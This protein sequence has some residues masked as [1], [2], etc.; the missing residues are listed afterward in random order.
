M[1][2]PQAAEASVS[3]NLNPH[4]NTRYTIKLSDRITN[5]SPSHSHYKTVKFNHKP[6]ATGKVR[7]TTV[8][9]TSTDDNQFNLSIRDKESAKSTKSST[10]EYTGQRRELKKTYVLLFDQASQTATL[11]PLEETYAFNL[12]SAPWE[13]DAAKLAEQYQQVR[14]RREKPDGQ[15]DAANDDADDLFSDGSETPRS[16]NES[17]FGDGPSDEEPEEGNPFDFRNFL[18]DAEQSEGFASPYSQSGTPLR[19]TTTSSNTATATTTTTAPARSTPLQQS[20]RSKAKQTLKPA[21][22]PAVKQQQTSTAAS[23]KRKSPDPEQ[24]AAKPK[25]K[26]TTSTTT[27]SSATATATKPQ[28]TP[29]IRLDRRASAR[30]IDSALSTS[31]PAPAPS[32]Q[33]SSKTSSR[34]SRE[35]TPDDEDDDDDDA[36]GGL[37]IDWGGSDKSAG[38]RGRPRR[39]IALAF[40]QGVTGDGPVSLRSAA[41]SASPNSRLH[42]PSMRATTKHAPDVIEFGAGDEDEEDEDE[43]ERPGHHLAHSHEQEVDDDDDD[44]EQEDDDGYAEDDEDADGDVDPLTLGS[45]AAD[46]L[47]QS[48]QQQQQQQVELGGGEEEEEEDDDDGGDNFEDDFEEQMAQALA[49]AAEEDVVQHEESEE[50]SEEE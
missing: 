34:T 49:S 14:P 44:E 25:D 21:P 8:K 38:G 28:P 46:T 18:K 13:K 27:T 30:P 16:L 32:T 50:E 41:D 5:P 47:Q 31:A 35:P 9:P 33:S 15:L 1:A 36:F 10:Y 2:S 17:M 19:T 37:E 39:S 22:K 20:E 26:A 29:A 42:T 7:T 12:K 45:P 24:P 4:Q 3:L 23:R 43:D 6:R 48:N 11:E 40:E